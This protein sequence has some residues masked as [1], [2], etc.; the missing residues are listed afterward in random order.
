MARGGF[1]GVGN[2]GSL[3]ARNL[4]RAGHNLK[5]YDSV[6]GSGEL[7]VQSDAKA[8]SSVKDAVV[9]VRSEKIDASTG[10]AY[11]APRAQAGTHQL[12]DESIRLPH[13]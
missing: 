13:G 4:I 11:P 1:I 8:A 2:M 10:D 7:V 3:M 5:V 6:R 12:A 9:C